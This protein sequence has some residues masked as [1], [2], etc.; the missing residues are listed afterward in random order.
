MKL[1]AF[2]DYSLRVL[3][4]L[5]SQPASRATI[6]EIAQVFEVSEH[7]LTKVV[8]GL[9][10]NGWLANVRGKGGGLELAMPPEL[11]V[12]GRVVRQTEGPSMLAECFSKDRS[13]CSIETICRLRGV[14][15][16]AGRAFYE[17]LDRY[18]LADLVENRQS[19]AKVLFVDLPVRA[20]A[21]RKAA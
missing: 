9:G 2:T 12:V 17:V 20:P 10:K 18:T 6:A 3:M 21:S 16:E 15:A 13:D 11:I 1:T 19:L 5:A 14:L 7:H 4:Y 8:H